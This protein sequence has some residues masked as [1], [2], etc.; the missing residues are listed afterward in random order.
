MSIQTGYFGVLRQTEMKNEPFYLI[1]GGVEVREQADYYFD[2]QARLGYQG[3]LFQYTLSGEGIYEI[4]GE[5][6]CLSP[7]QGFF[8]KFPYPSKYYAKQNT[9]NPWNILYL[10]FDGFVVDH[11]CT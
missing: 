4:D 6:Y 7:G 1:D 5:T 9:K 8:V 3:Y 11:F 10:H 2:N